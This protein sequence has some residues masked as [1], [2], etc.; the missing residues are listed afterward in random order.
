MP[1]WN[2]RDF[3]KGLAASTAFPLFAISGT[4]AS[5]KIL[6]ANDTIRVGVAG[7]NGRGSSHIDEFLKLKTAGVEITHLI[8]PDS[9]L[10]PSRSKRI[11]DA[12][13][14]TPV[15]VQDIRQALDDK[16]LDVISVATCNHW[17]ALITVWSCQAG[18]DV[19]VEKP[20]SH[21][22]LE[23]R[24]CAEAAA[25]YGRV[26]QHGTQTR[27]SQ[28]VASL[29]QVVQSGKYGR[30]L[31]SKGYCC[32]PRWS[33]G[34]KPTE[35]PPAHLD[36]NLWLGPAPQ[37]PF[38]PNLVHYNWHW[39]WDFGNGDTGNQGVHEM[40][41]ARW[42]IKG[43]TLPNRVWSLGGRFL[44]DGPDQGE[45]PNMQLAVYEF[46]DVLL[47]FETRGL[48]KEGEKFQNKVTNE[49]YTTEGVIRR[50]GNFY[51]KDGGKPERA[52]GGEDVRVTPGDAFGS[53]LAAV[54]SRNPRDNNCDA[55][56]AHYSSALCHLGNISFRLGTPARFDAANK[57]IGDN[58][59]IVESFETIKENL[60]AVNVSLDNADY[61]MGRSLVVDAKTEKFVD[62]DQ[63]N[64]LLTRPY[65]A[66]FV[67]P[68]VV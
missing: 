56:V 61:L 5:G 54:R 37:Q 59:Q 42:A 64:Q 21:N 36:F 17:H 46:G 26:V 44:P 41:V 45:T 13:G 49:F 66:P 18:K 3:V 28:S 11:Q 23:G 32:K 35:S 8:D 10:Y 38:H 7:I 33:I 24:R 12:T 50:D 14:R 68:D 9:S 39:F 60:R 40:D 57:A 22:V 34:K 63:A 31:V 27:S 29:I 1:R 47:V 15:C 43:A 67:V 48:V 2:R 58:K 19:Y 16:N 4:K 55:E 62:D 20:I 6:G 30:L 53:F 51:P 52:K 25:K 65:R